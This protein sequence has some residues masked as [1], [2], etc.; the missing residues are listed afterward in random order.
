MTRILAIVQTYEM[1]IE[2]LKMYYQEAF[3]RMDPIN[4][5]L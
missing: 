1:N 2:N 4:C 5:R 3:V